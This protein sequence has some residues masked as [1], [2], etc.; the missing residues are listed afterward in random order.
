MVSPPS[1]LTFAKTRIV[2]PVI[3]ASSSPRAYVALT[4]GMP[5]VYPLPSVTAGMLLRSSAVVLP[6]LKKMMAE[7]PA[8]AALLPLISNVQVPRWISAML[9]GVKPSKSS[10]SQPLVDVLPRPS[11]T[12]IG[13][14]GAVTSPGS[15]CG[16]APKSVPSV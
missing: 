6:W 7:A 3:P 12:S 13:V 9:P 11:W 1:R 16:V 5:P 8:A 14:T 10:G 2:R 4:A 15:D